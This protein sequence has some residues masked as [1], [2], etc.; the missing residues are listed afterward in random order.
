MSDP[1]HG[2]VQRLRDT[3]DVAADLRDLAR[4]ELAL[5][6]QPRIIRVRRLVISEVD[7]FPELGLAF[8]EQGPGRIINA[9]A[10]TF[11]RLTARGLLYCDDPLVA[12]THFNWLIMSQPLNRAMFLHDAAVP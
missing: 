1:V 2:K 3:G 10:E 5:V 11:E 6:M 7:R 9:L 8:Y 4:S 12:A